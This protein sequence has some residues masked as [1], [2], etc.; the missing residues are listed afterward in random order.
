MES[1]E[2]ITSGVDNYHCLKSSSII[3]SLNSNLVS[4]TETIWG[5]EFSACCSWAGIYPRYPG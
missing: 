1:L 4:V 5:F 2:V 3:N